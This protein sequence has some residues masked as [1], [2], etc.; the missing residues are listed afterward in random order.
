MSDWASYRASNVLQ[1]LHSNQSN[2][3]VA[4]VPGF[5]RAAGCLGILAIMAVPSHAATI[6][7]PADYPTISEAVSNST[8]G[9]TI[10]VSSGTYSGESLFTSSNIT[11]QSVSGAAS[12][13]I[14]YT[15][16]FQ[17]I[18]FGGAE[19]LQGFTLKNASFFEG[20]IQAFGPATIKDCVFSDNSCFDGGIV[21]LFNNATVSGC[22]F[23]NNEGSG[24]YVNSGF[25]TIN[26]CSFNGNHAML[27]GAINGYLASAS[28]TGCTFTGNTADGNAGEWGGA[29]TW[30]NGGLTLTQCT[31]DNNSSQQGGAVFCIGQG[32][33]ASVT[34]NQC[35]FKNNIA[36]QGGALCMTTNNPQ[37]VTV[38]LSDCVFTGNKA[39]DAGNSPSDD[40]AAIYA[41]NLLGPSTLNVT[42]CSFYGNDVPAG[43]SGAG[44][45]AGASNLTLTV[46]NSIL[47]GDISPSEIST[48]TNSDALNVGYSDIN[49]SGFA[50]LDGNITADPLYANPGIGDL[51]LPGS[52]PC[53]EAGNSAGAPLTDYSDYTWGSAVS[54]G[55]YSPVRFALNTPASATLGTAFPFTVTALAADN[56]SVISNYAG[57]VHFTSTDGSALLPADSMLTNGAGTFSATLNSAGGQKITAA[58]TQAAGISGTSATI[59][60]SGQTSQF[61]VA[62]PSTTV[63]GTPFTFTVTAK[64]SLGNTVT[65]YTG[66]VHFTSDDPTATLP[67]DTTLVNGVGT[68]QATLTRATTVTIRARDTSTSS[69]T[70]T[71]GTTVSA[72][73]VQ[74][75]IITAPSTTTT[76][77]ANVVNVSARDAYGNAV[78]NFSDTIHFTSTDP[79]AVLPADSALTNGSKQFTV[80]YLT[81]GAQSVTATSVASPSLTATAGSTVGV[82]A[83]KLKVTAPAT[84]TAGVP[85]SFTV[86]A[87]DAYGN[88]ATGYSGTV[89]FTSSD[90]G[91]TVPANVTLT[92]GAGTFTA[93]LTKSGNQTI[94]AKDTATASILGQSGAIAVTSGTA[95][96]L[97]ITAPASIT[98]GVA[99]S[100]TVTAKDA[101]GNVTTANTDTIHLTSTDPKATLPA[102]AALVKGTKSFSVRLGT[103]GNQTVTATDAASSLSVTSSSISVL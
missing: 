50:G 79:K 102:N 76:G 40:G 90:T 20:V 46:L 47:Y 100:V 95:V 98:K 70:G 15:G 9:D 16:S 80:K 64:N 56:A 29:I 101:Y 44:T 66:T 65:G 88:T 68:F 60:A 59:Q 6:N 54:M 33:S 34:A 26:N 11:I 61:T 63:A 74:N 87:V 18:F 31:F 38:N 41:T 83:T 23:N 51:H 17:G 55:A 92:G 96:S 28:V 57:T 85:V 5:L 13:I 53:T 21:S 7:V 48:L 35:L 99:F 75:L 77:A 30:G 62:I 82:V 78:K 4:I 81:P 52:S 69:I 42:N 73:A 19:T 89:G 14:D 71:A 32:A 1:L 2:L 49:Q 24:I 91:A 3:R 37:T 36:A 72:A 25:G 94:T 86:A 43:V 93:T 22:S 10:L 84:A 27:G 12:T 97:A 8:D 45:I 39:T 58:D 103:T 67:A